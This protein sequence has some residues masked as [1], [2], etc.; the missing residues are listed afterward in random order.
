MVNLVD[1][2]DAQFVIVRGDGVTSNVYTFIPE[3]L[4]ELDWL[5]ERYPGRSFTVKV[6][7]VAHEDILR[8]WKIPMKGD[9]K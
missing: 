8:K 1:Y 2:R 5:R 4:A 7:H 9:P 6:L 3:L